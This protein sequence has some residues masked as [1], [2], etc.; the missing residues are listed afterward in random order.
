MSAPQRYRSGAYGAMVAD[1][2]G[3]WV[4][5]SDASW[6]PI[7]SAPKDGTVF[8]INHPRGIRRAWWAS[9]RLYYEAPGRGEM[10]D[11]DIAHWMPSP[12]PPR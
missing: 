2:N 10:V 5:W 11:D 6:Q 4:R 8:Y 9:D 12:E 7:D 1:D 3:P